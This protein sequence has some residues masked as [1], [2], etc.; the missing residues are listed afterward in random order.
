MKFVK[1]H[2]LGNDFVFLEDKNGADKDFSQLAIKM[3]APHTG[4]GAD[5]II[6]I[7]PSDKADVRM[8]II[9][10]DG[11]EA[12]MCGNGIRCFAKYVY[13]N[14]IIDKKEFAVE[15]LAGIMKPKVTVGDD[16]KVS[17]VTINMGKPF[18][19]RA[20]IPME[21]PSG[22][23]IDEPIDID[24]KTYKITSLLMGVP[25]TMTYVKDV[26]AVDLHELGPKFETYK[27]FPR[28]TNMN[29][30]QVIDDHTI[31][32]EMDYQPT[33]ADRPVIPKIGMR[34][35]LPADYTQI[36]YY[37]R[38]PWENYP[39][40]K[41]SAF[42]SE[43]EMPLSEYETE[44]IHPQDNGNRCD[45]R[46]FEISSQ[47]SAISPR[48]RIEGLQP[49]CIRAWDYGEEDLDAAPRHPQDIQRGRFVNLNIDLNIHGVGGADT[50]GKHTLPQYTIDGNQPYHYA[51]ILKVQ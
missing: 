24:G 50:W 28:K 11:S 31:L 46:W 38:G 12:E 25:H 6:V 40:R 18:T 49:L 48:L 13:D 35:R 20:Q 8:R 9:N 43:Y 16:G 27:A 41:R 10:A 29:F 17:L 19:D 36:R 33:A 44:Y 1:M 34:M 37:G 32:V 26:D 7:V 39:D 15:T 4:I 3:C 45:I 22:P 30:V 21:G 42:L 14:G 47:T 23:V 2:G 5:G 51:F